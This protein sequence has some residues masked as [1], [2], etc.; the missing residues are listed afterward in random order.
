MFVVTFAFS[1]I[2]IYD[3][4]NGGISK[5]RY[6]KFTNTIVMHFTLITLF[7][8]IITESI[9]CSL[10]KKGLQNS[11]WCYDLINLRN[12]GITKHQNVDDEPYGGGTG[13]VMRPDVLGNA[14]DYA[15]SKFKYDKIL[16]PSP[17]G[18]LFNQKHAQTLCKN[19]NVLIICGRFEGI[20]ER[21]IEQYE[22]EEVSIGDYILS[23]GELA[24]LVIMDVCIRL[25]DGVIT[26][27]ETI[28][29]ESLSDG[30]T[31]GMLEYPLYTRPYN[32]NNMLVPEVLISGD[33]A[34]IKQ[35]KH[36]QSCKITRTRRPDIYSVITNNKN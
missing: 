17:R 3:F 32:W 29:E 21:I 30:S 14:I 27:T 23:G 36:E 9:F 8:E 28:K 19:S 33:H 13:L 26:N 7:P 25:I 16:Y 34:K 5:R 6:Q 11:L 2:I 4:C 15:L 35:W 24:A 22:V 31:S 18:S 20:D 12:F 10:A 1:L